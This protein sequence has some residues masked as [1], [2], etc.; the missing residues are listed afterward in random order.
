MIL[1]IAAIVVAVLVAGIAVFELVGWID[2]RNAR[3]RFEKM[4]PEER[5][6][7]QEDM[8]KAQAYHNS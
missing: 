2:E 7:Y 8:H 1:I 6:K 3:K 5:F 4:T